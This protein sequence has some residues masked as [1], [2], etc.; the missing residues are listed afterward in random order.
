MQASN[1][2]LAIDRCLRNGFFAVPDPGANG[3]IDA[4]NKGRVICEIETSTA[5]SIALPA[6]GG[7]PVGLELM[8]VL[9]TDGGDLTLTG[10]QSG[11][12][13]LDTAGNMARFVVCSVS[14]DPTANV[15]KYLSPV[16][17]QR[18]RASTAATSGTVEGAYIRL[19][20]TADGTATGEAL[21]AFTNVN[22]NIATA[23]G[24][25]ISLSFSAVAGGSECSGL[26]V[27]VRGTT[28]IPNIASWA[29]TGTLYAGMFE[30]YNDGSASDPAGLT[31]LA[32]L[33]LSNSGDTTGAAD[34]DDD[35]HILSIQ[36]FTAAA[37]VAHAV[38]ST[39]LTELP[40]GS[41]GLRIKVGSSIYYIPAVAAAEWN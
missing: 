7:L 21:R 34:V 32:L 16:S 31:E 11:S 26:G 23:H 8:V 39:S 27:A 12:V 20:F 38:S 29:P 14:T 13:I 33:C 19:A 1:L 24:G 28:H 10:A 4:I 37:G 17:G 35:A 3:T 25:H 18:E 40:A 41:I 5:E 36:G 22:A 15:W 9:K 30:L 2:P 6:P